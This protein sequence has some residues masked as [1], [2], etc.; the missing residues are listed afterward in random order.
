MGE[1]V[2]VTIRNTRRDAIK[3]LEDEEKKKT[4]TEDDR[5]R[6]KKEIEDLTKKYIEQVD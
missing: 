6:G 2:K 3:A 5:D 1:R 4:I